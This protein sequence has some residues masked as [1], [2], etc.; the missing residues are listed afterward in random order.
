M[1]R[2]A[3]NVIRRIRESVLYRL[4][5]AKLGIFYIRRPRLQI[6]RIAGG[7]V[8][9]SFPEK[10]RA[11]HEHEFGRIFFE[12]CYR[13]TSIDEPVRTVLDIGANIGLFTL[14]AR[15]QFTKAEIHCYEPNPS[16]LDHLRSHCASVGAHLNEAAVGKI[17][18]EVSL[19]HAG[20]SL[21]SV[22][23]VMAGGG[24]RLESFSSVIAS[25]GNVDL[26]KLD[27]EG[28]EWD[29]FQCN[30]AWQRVRSLAME[31]H[32]WA[33]PGS[34]TDCLRQQLSDLGFSQID[35]EPS[36]NGP[37]GFAFASRLTSR[38]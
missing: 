24:I 8:P 27:C 3:T 34:T 28:A 2:S 6:I 7:R 32:L 4:Q 19:E 10:E 18:G 17:S 1:L 22:T 21:H 14:A 20:N 13:L 29:I 12:D 5:W 30:D 37:W 15:R 25:I 11:I 33:K 31:Y 26:L 16:V 36:P 23:K 35:I 38:T 9:L